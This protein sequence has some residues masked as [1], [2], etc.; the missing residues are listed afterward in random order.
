MAHNI[1]VVSVPRAVGILSSPYFLPTRHRVLTLG[2]PLP[3]AAHGQSFPLDES[4]FLPPGNLRRI[5]STHA[6]VYATTGMVFIFQVS[7]FT[8]ARQ[9]LKKQERYSL[10]GM[11]RERSTWRC[12]GSR[13]P[14]MTAV[15]LKRHFSMCVIGIFQPSA[16]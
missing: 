8:C 3:P 2:A 13:I 4:A 9:T 10:S 11:G 7:N 5:N 12:K 14:T 1:L 6:Y 15:I 16:I